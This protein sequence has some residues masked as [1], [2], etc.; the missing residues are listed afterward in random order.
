M[1]HQYHSATFLSII[2]LL[3]L[4]LGLPVATEQP[5]TRQLP[6][7]GDQFICRQPLGAIYTKEA[8]TFRVFAPTAS[9]LQLRLYQSPTGGKPQLF[10]FTK[11]PSDGS[12][13]ITVP[14]DCLG[15]YYTLTA[16]GADAAFNPERELIDPYA[17]AVTAHNG[18]AIVTHDTTPIAPR[19]SFPPAEAIILKCICATLPSTR[20]AAF[21]AAASIW[22]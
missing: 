9:K 7:P 15:L 10:D 18:R 17:R 8:T 20:I 13:D 21:N 2:L 6:H 5:A 12:W 4:M 11:H 14:G 22:L 16:G 19:P 3:Q 1:I